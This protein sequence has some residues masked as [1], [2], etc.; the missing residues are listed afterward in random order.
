MIERDLAEDL[1]GT[2][3]RCVNGELMFTH[4]TAIVVGRKLVPP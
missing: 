4:R 2:N 3:P 1:S